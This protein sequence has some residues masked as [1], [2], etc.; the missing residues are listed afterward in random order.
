MVVS[1]G[2]GRGTDWG[3]SR[4]GQVC[5]ESRDVDSGLLVYGWSSLPRGGDGE[6]QVRGQGERVE[7][8]LD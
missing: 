5:R 7:G 1:R 4:V 3:V 6:G 8:V 2:I